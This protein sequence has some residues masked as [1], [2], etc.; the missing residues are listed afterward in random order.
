VFFTG[1]SQMPA[2]LL[3]T[4]NRQT[5]YLTILSSFVLINAGAIFAALQLGANITGVACCAVLVTALYS[6]LLFHYALRHAE[7]VRRRRLATLVELCWPFAYMGASL[8]LLNRLIPHTEALLPT[9][10]RTVLAELL[11]LVLSVPL[12]V[13]AN[14]RTSVVSEAITAI[15]GRLRRGGARP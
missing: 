7:P 8:G 2:V 11:W 10:G 6:F 3:N 1:I 5:R 9:L 14:R 12:L 4:T 15:R 13:V